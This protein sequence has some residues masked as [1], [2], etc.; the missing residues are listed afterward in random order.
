MA[1]RAVLLRGS[2]RAPLEATRQYRYAFTGLSSGRGG[3][4]VRDRKVCHQ[5]VV[6]PV[7]GLVALSQ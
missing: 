1:D 5:T 6:G 4:R 7:H 3:E 2:L